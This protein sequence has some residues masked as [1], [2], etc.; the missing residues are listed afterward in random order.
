MHVLV[1][2]PFELSHS[3]QYMQIEF[4]RLQC[5]LRSDGITVPESTSLLI[6]PIMS[7]KIYNKIRL[8]TLVVADD[9]TVDLLSYDKRVNQIFTVAPRNFQRIAHEISALEFQNNPKQPPDDDDVAQIE[10][11]VDID[12]VLTG[13]IAYFSAKLFNGIEMNTRTMDEHSDVLRPRPNLYPI[14]IA[15]DL[16]TGQKLQAIFYRQFE[17]TSKTMTMEWSV[18]KPFIIPIHGSKGLYDKLL[19]T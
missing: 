4:R 3:N 7:S 18:E 8:G 12:C 9:I 15:K 6:A 16:K 19:A 10:F 5:F 13:F 14:R 2:L 17:S 1:C 11:Q